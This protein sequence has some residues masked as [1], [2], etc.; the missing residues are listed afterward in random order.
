MEIEGDGIG[1]ERTKDYICMHVCICM[2]NT[3]IHYTYI[4]THTCTQ[5]HTYTC[6]H[7]RTHR[8]THSL[9]QIQQGWLHQRPSEK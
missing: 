6:A 3:Y 1:R 4:H 2:Y 5:T 9:T 7:T 8:G